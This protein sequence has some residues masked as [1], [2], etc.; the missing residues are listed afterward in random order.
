MYSADIDL[1]DENNSHTQIVL[2]VGRGRRVLDLGC[3]DG[4][5]GRALASRDCTVTGVELDPAAAR[6]AQEVLDEVVV[7]DL[8]TL[9]LAATFAGRQFDAIVCGDVLEHVRDPAAVLRA[10][11]GLLA[12]GGS[13]VASVPNV[14]HGGVRLALLG[15]DWT[16]QDRGLLD[17]THLRFFTRTSLLRL[18]QEAGLVP[19][20]VRRTT[21]GVFEGE[22]RA[23]VHRVPPD[24]VA[25]VEADPDAVTYQVVVKGVV[26]APGSELAAAAHELRHLRE[27]LAALRGETEGGPSRLEQLEVDLACARAAAD[28]LQAEVARLHA[29]LGERDNALERQSARH[30]EVELAYLSGSR[31]LEQRLARAEALRA[32]AQEMLDRRL[33]ERVIQAGRRRLQRVRL[34]D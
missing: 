7:G 26:D 14:A 9:D 22:V 24:A 15:G 32:Q 31:E 17:R 11:A 6:E 28:A 18:F 5:L 27:E 8:E 21:V 33:D 19:L 2:L 25:L 10:A 4:S 12:P 34:R 1:S 13:I 23:D 16:Y 20:E 3:A 29:E 30:A